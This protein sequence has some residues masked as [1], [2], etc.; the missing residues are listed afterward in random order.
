MSK[1]EVTTSVGDWVSISAA[2]HP[3]RLCFVS[4]VGGE[5]VRLT[6]TQVAERV[7]RIAAGLVEEYS[8][9]QGERVAVMA[10][11]SHQYVELWLACAKMGI[12][13]IPF[14]YRLSER[15]VENLLRR[16]GAR[17]L[18]ASDEYL[19]MGAR[20]A[21]TVPS[22]RALFSIT[23]DE[24]AEVDVESL[25]SRPGRPPERLVEDDDLFAI[26]F[27]SGTT[28]MAKGVMQSQRMMKFM[29]PFM[30]VEYEVKDPGSEFRYSAAPLFHIAG[31]GMVLVGIL[32]GFP[33][34]IRRQFHAEETLEWLQEGGLT[35]TFL[36][37]TM[38][39]NIL[40]L[41]GAE[42]QE[43]EDLQTILYGAS[44][45]PPTL[46]RRAMDTFKCDF[47]NAFGAGT[48]TGLQTALS[49]ADHRR[50]ANGEPH[51]LQSIG[52][53]AFGVKLRLTDP[54]LN[55]VSV[56]EV[57]E[58]TT[59]SE[60]VMSGYLDMPEETA[61]AFRGG[62]FRAGDL[63]Y[64]DEDGYLYLAGRAKDMI[65]R[66][67]ENIY[68]VEIESVLAEHPDVAEVAVVGL[69]DERWGEIVA[70][71]VVPA[72]GQTPRPEDL[73]SLCRER[74]AAYKVPVAFAFRDEMPRNA[75]GKI[76]KRSLRDLPETFD[77][78]TT[79]ATT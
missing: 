39:H 53:P 52:R 18:V 4:D 64:A 79:Q 69:P 56:G 13:V 55:D 44:P 76:L 32:Y 71:V 66:G 37:P 47:V 1:R 51:L 60:S 38:I 58:V 27:T 73:A 48:E 7:D 46:L 75:S 5:E 49:A 77:H 74:L 31:I 63:A 21:R 19:D 41:P 24:R 26:S 34:L 42:G 29:V 10:T 9:A 20:L 6:F 30:S 2:R 72:G 12:T 50:A 25:A 23:P 78:P 54:D 40:A 11:D 57:G 59:R 17:V 61:E 45:M 28:G 65:I 43:Y 8:L 70:A 14:N 67:G 16:A 33:V 35:T 62:W 22:V 68:P 15:E 3:S 36:V